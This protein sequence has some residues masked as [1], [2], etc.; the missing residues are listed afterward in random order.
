M[1]SPACG[2]TR[3]TSFNKVEQLLAIAIV[4]SWHVVNSSC[5]VENASCRGHLRSL[6][7]SFLSSLQLDLVIIR[8][9]KPHLISAC[10][11]D[12]LNTT[13]ALWLFSCCG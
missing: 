5:D 2:I 8:H 13:N 11:P 6:V 7:P 1:M 3:L 10:I 12:V 9:V 4:G